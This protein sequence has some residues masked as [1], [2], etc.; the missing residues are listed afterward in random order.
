M[1]SP[2]CISKGTVPP[3]SCIFGQLL[4]IGALLL[5]IIF[6]TRYKQVS[7]EGSSSQKHLP[8]GGRVLQ[9]PPEEAE[10]KKDEYN[11]I[12]ARLSRGS[13]SEGTDVNV[14]TTSDNYTPCSVLW[15]T[16]KRRRWLW[17]ISLELPWLLV[18]G[19]SISGCRQ[20]WRCWHSESLSCV[21]QVYF[22]AVIPPRSSPRLVTWMRIVLALVDTASLV[23][24]VITG[25]L[26]ILILEQHG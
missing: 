13:G 10:I 17:F 19:L 5:A 11:I 2:L 15:E 20:L 26:A 24:T 21:R 25:F 22:T 6:Y 16:F 23:T 9:K 12:V 1:W 7:R 18:W 14:S 8:S 3:E 4:N